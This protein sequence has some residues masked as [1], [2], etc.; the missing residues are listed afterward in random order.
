MTDPKKLLETV[1]SLIELDVKHIAKVVKEGK[2]EH[3]QALD[4]TRYVS[5]LRGIIAKR[6]E[7]A[8]DE[9]DAYSR[10]TIEELRETA[11]RAVEKL[12]A[13]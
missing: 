8:E 13:K 4:L 1:I 6:Q 7:D 2:L 3:T 10:M 11:K 9:Q 5:T 12:E